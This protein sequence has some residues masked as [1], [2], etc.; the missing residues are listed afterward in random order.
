MAERCPARSYPLFYTFNQESTLKAQGRPLSDINNNDRMAEGVPN[1]GDHYAQHVPNHRRIQG[2]DP[3]AI[4]SFIFN[5][6]EELGNSAHTLLPT[7]T[8]LGPREA[9]CASDP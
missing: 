6:R 8:P 3:L 5:V 9:L 1:S 2:V 4:Q 7:I